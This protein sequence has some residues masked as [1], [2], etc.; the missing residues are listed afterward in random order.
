MG[1]VQRLMGDEQ[2][3]NNTL[4]FRKISSQI[5]QYTL[6]FVHYSLSIHVRDY[7]RSWSWQTRVYSGCLSGS[8]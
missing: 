4:A 2:L 6:F 7:T 3:A 1:N 8:G 5:N